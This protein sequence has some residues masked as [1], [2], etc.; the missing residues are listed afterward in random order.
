MALV[1]E[2]RAKLY[3]SKLYE[4]L[5]GEVTSKT[6]ETSESLSLH[7]TRSITVLMRP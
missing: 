7:L 3:L 1:E 4:N 2:P 6:K 5:R